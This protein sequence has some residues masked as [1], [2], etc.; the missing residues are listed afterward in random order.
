LHNS[1]APSRASG[2]RNDHRC[3]YKEFTMTTITVHTPA[4]VATPR[5]AHW[6]AWLLG[7]IS[8]MAQKPSDKRQAH[9]NLSGRIAES[10]E[11]RRYAQQFMGHDPR[12]AADLF[13]AA[14]RHERS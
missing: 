11:V 2:G 9:R 10:A 1:C 3:P 5:G 4:P 7:K 6:A 8:E 13:A 14:D 12:F